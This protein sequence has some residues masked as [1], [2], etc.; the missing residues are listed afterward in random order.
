ME[1]LRLRSKHASGK[2][3]HFCT[4]LSAAATYVLW[5]QFLS[6]RY[7][8][9]PCNTWYPLIV[10][11]IKRI[12]RC[13]QSLIYVS[14][15][16]IKISWPIIPFIDYVQTQST[17]IGSTVN[18]QNWC[19]DTITKHF[20]NKTQLWCWSKQS[21]SVMCAW[22]KSWTWVQWKLKLQIFY[23]RGGTIIEI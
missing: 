16:G 17:Y 23:Y 6:N 2:F 8:R 9:P 13:T 21:K 4:N 5:L 18:V 11:C 3:E 15:C 7:S 19:F 22:K 12:G 10:P 20:P 1:T 14:N